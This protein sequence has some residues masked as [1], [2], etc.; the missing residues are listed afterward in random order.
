VKREIS[1]RACLLMVLPFTR[2]LRLRGRPGAH[3][4]SELIPV[5][6][7]GQITSAVA[8][9]LAAFKHVIPVAVGVH[10]TAGEPARKWFLPEYWKV[11]KIPLTHPVARKSIRCR[12]C[13]RGQEGQIKVYRSSQPRRA[14]PGRSKLPGPESSDP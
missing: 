14:L 12:H 6:A 7:S 1:A 11:H 8:D 13:Y 2:G 10:A 4:T 5:N 3:L 9:H